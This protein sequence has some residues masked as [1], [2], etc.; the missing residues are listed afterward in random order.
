MLQSAGG[1]D[2]LFGSFTPFRTPFHEDPTR[3]D[4]TP[5][6]T[7]VSDHEAKKAE[8]PADG[9]LVTIEQL[10]RLN[11]ILYKHVANIPT[12]QDNTR[13]SPAIP[14]LPDDPSILTSMSPPSINLDIGHLLSMTHEFRTLA[15]Q[16]GV[17]FPGTRPAGTPASGP[18]AYP[19]KNT[20]GKILEPGAPFDHSTALLLLSCYMRL[21]QAHGRALRILHQLLERQ[22]SGDLAMPELLPDLVIDGFSLAGHGSLQMGLV[23][24]LCEQMFNSIGHPTLDGRSKDDMDWGSFGACLT[25]KLQEFG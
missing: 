8:C 17:Q 21:K 7:G 5:F 13:P 24:T 11:L 6:R 22:S 19:R 10:S 23:V 2:G 12:A 16:L 25:E 9:H 1:S 15:D 18:P 14:T 20:D 4:G 3:N